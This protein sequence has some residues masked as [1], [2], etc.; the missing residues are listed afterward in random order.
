M[1]TR[2]WLNR[3]QV[4]P[5]VGKRQYGSGRAT[6]HV[7]PL[8]V[9]INPTNVTSVVASGLAISAGAGDMRVGQ[10]VLL[11]VDFSA[12][13]TVGSANGLPT[14]TLNDGGVAAYA[15]GSGSAALNFDYTVAP[16]QN[17]GDLTVSSFNLNGSTI[18]DSGKANADLTGAVTNPAGILQIDTIA[19][20][21][22]ISLVGAMSQPTGA[23]LQF[24]VAFA[25][26]VSGVDAGGF[27]LTTTGVSGASIT[28]VAQE[29]DAA[30]YTV[31]VASG[32]GTGTVGLNI[33]G[34]NVR[35]RA[36]NGFGGG[37][38]HA[39]PGSPIAVGS[40]PSFAAIA[41][42]DGDG[43]PDIVVSNHDSN[44]VSVL[45]GTGAGTFTRAAGSPFAVDAG[46]RALAIV[47]VNGDG[48]PDIV[49]A[50]SNNN[51]NSS[52]SVSIL[53]NAGN[54]S[55][56]AAG[57]PIAIGPHPYSV[58]VADVNGD[59]K[60]DIVTPSATQ[61][62]AT[63]LL[64]A[65]NG[66]FSPA[67]G[68]PVAVGRGPIAAVLGD[69]NGDGIVDIFTAD[70]ED[71]TANVV[72]GTGGG[73]FSSTVS[74]YPSGAYPQSVVIADVDGDGKPDLVVGDEGDIN[75]LLNTGTGSFVGAA[76]SPFY[77]GG[78]FRMAVA[79]VNGDG[80]I[81]VVTES[82][83]VFLGNGDGTF[84]A[85]S[86]SPYPVGTD[87]NSVAIADLDGDGR[88][89]LVFT[90]GDDNNAFILLNGAVAQ[91]GPV[92]DLV[93]P[94]ATVYVNAD[95]A[96]LSPGTSVEDAD[97]TVDGD[98]P[99]TIGFDAFADLPEG[100]AAV[101]GSGT[102]VLFPGNY[103][104]A[105]TLAQAVTFR[106]P[107]A[108]SV[109]GA[110]GGT[111]SL[112]KNGSGTLTLGGT[113]TYGGGTTLS[114]GALLVDGSLASAISIASDATLGGSGTVVDVTNKGGIVSPGIA[115]TPHSLGVGSVALAGGNAGTLDL[116]LDGNAP[117]LSDR[118]VAGGSSIDIGGA[119]L[120][121]SIANIHDG[122]TFTI[123]SVP[124][125][126][127][128]T[129][130]FDDLPSDGSIITVGSRQFSIDYSLGGDGN[131]VSLT[132]L[133]VDGTP[134]LSA[135]I[136]NGGSPYVSSGLASQQHSIVG[137]VRFMFSGAVTL[138]ASDFTIT[139]LNGT[140]VVPT[141]NATGTAGNTVW[142]V[143][144]SGAGTTAG[145]I[146]DGEYNLHLGA[147]FNSDFSFYRLLGDFDGSH[148]V[149]FSDF[150]TFNST[151]NRP[152]SDPLYIG[153]ADFDGSG[154]SSPTTV[155]FADFLTL[156][157]NFN[158]SVPTPYPAN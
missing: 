88:L 118:I 58:A 1:S 158:R 130:R 104:D 93:S 111:G 97:P 138:A 39:A 27:S 51:S 47:D 73:S 140:T 57:A 84:R 147:G 156:S 124:L 33:T 2:W 66:S 117:T 105:V 52:G 10:T 22:T 76:G 101:A 149:T 114:A 50:N 129:G 37:S 78:S 99:A 116:D 126:V 154:Q 36:G 102:I 86:G 103:P 54:G 132:A 141:L 65:G 143:T 95:W 91:P 63:V 64:G 151:F 108:V 34:S 69:V 16:G 112:T 32:T 20:T 123:L 55:F 121:L 8:E 72:L 5:T 94:P 133:A 67:V 35:D 127:T 12:P 136:F 85:A 60:P 89:D 81:D 71:F 157:S 150:L 119:T 144:F 155:D 148:D 110:I 4:S 29:A 134:T 3:F 152:T 24:A 92:Y 9:R 98:Q 62:T 139:G 79:D 21:A 43:I 42:V 49:T 96:N 122:D 40:D 131:D 30:H 11:T 13:V 74:H 77:S 18:K 125:G 115:G 113:D 31:T 153:A 70:S 90:S 45:L 25:E 135:T 100:A 68:S 109:S 61:Y 15:G 19:P 14:L 17:T 44:N 7:E 146:D 83:S 6:L 145:S 142:T 87:P 137:S 107:E 56:S 48:K 106:V 59:G 80:R 28:S 46:P 38:F 41:D 82:G 120:S 75:V 23:T 26:P 128:V 53:L